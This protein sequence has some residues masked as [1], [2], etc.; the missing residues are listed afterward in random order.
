[1]AT[2]LKPPDPQIAVI[3][4]A[5]GDLTRRKLLPAFWHLFVEG[6]L[7]QGFAIVG[8]ARSQMTDEEFGERARAAIK[9]FAKTDPAGEEWEEFRQLL[10][11]VSGEFESELAMEHLC[12]HLDSIDKA[13]HTSGGRF[14]YCATP[15][16]AYPLIVARIGESNM[17][18]DAKIVV[19]K[20]FG[21][22]LQSAREL[23]AQL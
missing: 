17:Q 1:M 19:E 23:N 11:Y 9:E 22:D 20:P 5:S 3:F 8:Y 12:E 15:A 6:L 4:G 13:R 10:S 21:R 18:P 7:P 16:S 2:S 14:F